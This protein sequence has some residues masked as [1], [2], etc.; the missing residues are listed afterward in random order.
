M[1]RR[2]AAL[3]ALGGLLACVPPM[4]LRTETRGAREFRRVE[5]VP[6]RGAP[7]TV[8]YASGGEVEGELLAVDEQHLWL[9]RDG[10]LVAVHRESIGSAQV[11]LGGPGGGTGAVMA[12]LGT[13]SA[14]SH[15]FLAVFSAPIW[16]AVGIPAAAVAGA[17]ARSRHEGPRQLHYLFHY[18]RYPQGL[19]PPLWACEAHPV[20]PGEG[21][22]TPPAE[23]RP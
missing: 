4:R 5:E 17:E 2:L 3:V 23:V 1:S 19:P 7:V 14:A 9:E 13:V 8:A 15:G 16:L 11:S 18:A 20:L 6:V 21:L 10:V 22:S 12:A